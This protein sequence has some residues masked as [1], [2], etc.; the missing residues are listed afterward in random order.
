MEL[1]NIV[2]HKIIKKENGKP[3]L[4]C[5]DHL[6]PTANAD[7][8]E[9]VERFLNVYSNR[10]PTYGTFKEDKKLPFSKVFSGVSKWKRFS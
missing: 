9:F 3:T 7:I 5:S 8:I 4:N 6:L 10:S 1:K 2:L